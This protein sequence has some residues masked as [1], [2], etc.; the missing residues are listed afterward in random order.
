VT[1][2]KPKKKATKKATLV[3]VCSDYRVT[4]KVIKRALKKLRVSYGRLYILKILGGALI[5]GRGEEKTQ[6][7]EVQTHWAQIERFVNYGVR[8][9]VF[10]GHGGGCLEAI[11]FLGL[12][13]EGASPEREKA[14][15]VKCLNRALLFSKRRNPKTPARIFFI[16]ADWLVGGH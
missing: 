12:Y 5:L 15:S 1:G 16:P 3:V 8:Q 4:E 7:S 10:M 2:K 11:N 9:F 14:E 6:N 13:E